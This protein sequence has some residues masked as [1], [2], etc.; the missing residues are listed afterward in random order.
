MKFYMPIEKVEE[1]ADGTLMVSGIASTE[2]TDSDG[3]VIQ[4]EAIKAALPDFFRYGTGALREMHQP[5]AAGTV[6]EAEVDKGVTY[7]T[8]TVVDP[9]AVTKVK[10]GVYKGFSVGGKV[11]GRD[12]ND[13]NI[14][15]G[16]KLVEVSL[17]DRPANPDAVITVWKAEASEDQSMNKTDALADADKAA[18]SQIAELLNK[19]T[20]SPSVLLKAAQAALEPAPAPRE[21]L[22]G[23]SL[24]KGMSGVASFAQLLQQVAWM[25]QDSA[26]E[27]EMEGDASALPAML[28][29]WLTDGVH[30]FAAMSAEETAELIAAITPPPAPLVQVIEAAASTGDLNKAGAKFSASSKATLADIHKAIKECCDKLDGLGYADKDDD[31]EDAAQSGDAD[32]AE[33]AESITGAAASDLFKAELAKRD[34]MLAAMQARLETLEAQPAPG[35]AFLKAVALDKQHDVNHDSNI[36]KA[37]VDELPPNATPQQRA[38]HELK[39][40]FATGGVPFMAR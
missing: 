26:W 40:V 36:G 32:K 30:I 38:H 5:M 6:D 8:A 13:R 22:A 28:R 34:D 24:K 20:I 39:K 9:V 7:I 4:A 31:V 11:T 12:P 35:K 14:I 18:V 3:E 25:A 27:A 19:G 1:Q 17:V 15:T 10:A 33:S 37:A 21:K 23:D 16:L 2:S 29:A